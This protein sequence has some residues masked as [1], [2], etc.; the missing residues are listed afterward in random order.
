M[1][2][3]PACPDRRATWGVERVS[4]LGANPAAN[5]ASLSPPPCHIAIRRCRRVALPFFS[6]AGIDGPLTRRQ[7]YDISDRPVAKKP[8]FVSLL[9]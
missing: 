9:P 1:W 8:H 6:Q 3:T 5:R 7:V 2:M 4:D